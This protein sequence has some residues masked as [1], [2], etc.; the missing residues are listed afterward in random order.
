MMETEYVVEF[1]GTGD[2]AWYQYRKFSDLV[3]AVQCF[4]TEARKSEITLQ[5]RLIEVRHDGSVR[6]RNEL[7]SPAICVLLALMEQRK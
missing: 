7:L 5:H 4:W 6:T 2:D 3:E 1:K